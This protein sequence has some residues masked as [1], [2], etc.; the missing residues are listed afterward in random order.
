M[1]ALP[2]FWRKGVVLRPAAAYS[3]G[4][5]AVFAMGRVLLANRHYLH[6]GPYLIRVVPQAR[7]SPGL[8]TGLK[9]GSEIH[10]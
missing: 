1:R 8:P 7:Q 4:A 5:S 6:W 9:T 3:W 2:E 10:P